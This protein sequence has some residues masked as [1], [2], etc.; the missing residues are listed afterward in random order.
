MTS[1]NRTALIEEDISYLKGRMD[2][3]SSLCALLIATHPRSAKIIEVFKARASEVAGLDASTTALKAYAH[4]FA[5]LDLDA[6]E[7]LESFYRDELKLYPVPQSG[8]H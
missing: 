3:I 8:G 1:N 4:G 5:G 2:A 7:T 6:E